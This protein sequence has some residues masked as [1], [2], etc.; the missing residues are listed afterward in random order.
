MTAASILLRGGLVGILGIRYV[1]SFFVCLR[2]VGLL[3][4]G[5][6]GISLED[7]RRGSAGLVGDVALWILADEEAAETVGAG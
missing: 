3:Y 7:I 5:G 4:G 1:F 2:G 6:F